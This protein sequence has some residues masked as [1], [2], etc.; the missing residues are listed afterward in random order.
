ML[1]FHSFLISRLIIRSG[2]RISHS[3]VPIS[4]RFF[5]F[6]FFYP[7]KCKKI[8]EIFWFYWSNMNPRKVYGRNKKCLN[9]QKSIKK[10]CNENEHLKLKL[11]IKRNAKC[12]INLKTPIREPF[13]GKIIEIHM[14]LTVLSI[15][16][17]LWLSIAICPIKHNFFCLFSFLLFLP[18]YTFW[19]KS[20][21]LT[22]KDCLIID[23][24]AYDFK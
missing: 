22:N 10:C 13:K 3:K 24:N 2:L 17:K 20:I 1:V 11:L 18:A 4:V 21:T 8:C 14:Y 7:M 5:M 12:T 9:P 15:F 16:R 19:M 23:Q 6:N